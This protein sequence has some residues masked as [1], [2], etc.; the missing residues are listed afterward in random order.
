M[1]GV[2]VTGWPPPPAARHSTR[3][4]WD[5][6][7]AR[8]RV[9][10]PISARC[11]RSPRLPPSGRISRRATPARLARCAAPAWLVLELDFGLLGLELFHQLGVPGLLDD[12]V[13]LGPVI[14][15]EADAF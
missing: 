13:E 15:H 5:R 7:D 4:R 14:R 3:G 10:S 8:V 11:P 6:P 1:L 12:L 2:L 9:T